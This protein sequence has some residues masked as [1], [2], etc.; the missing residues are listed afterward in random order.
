V[1]LFD[2]VRDLLHLRA[3]L[4]SRPDGAPADPE[5]YVATASLLVAAACED[6]DFAEA[7]RRAI[8]RGLRAAFGISRDDAVSV[9]EAAEGAAPRALDATARAVH[10]SFDT[11]QRQ[12]ILELLWNVVYADRIVDDVEVALAEQVAALLA[13]TPEQSQQARERAFQWFS[14]RRPA[15]SGSGT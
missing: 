1:E 9:L 14:T 6:Q 13:L 4:A 5:L 8:E 12:R 7:E 10:Q 2:R 15:P 11:G 3:P